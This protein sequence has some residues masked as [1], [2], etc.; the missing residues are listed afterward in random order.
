M[1]RQN[2]ALTPAAGRQ[3]LVR[4]F[5][6]IDQQYVYSHLKKK[7]CLFQQ[8]D[9]AYQDY[10][11][12]RHFIEL[13]IFAVWQS[14]FFVNRKNYSPYLFKADVYS[15]V[16]AFLEVYD[17]SSKA[18]KKFLIQR[19]RKGLR[20]GYD[21]RDLR[22]EFDVYTHVRQ[23]GLGIRPYENKHGKGFDFLVSDSE[24]EAEIEV[25]HISTH[26]GHKIHQGD[27]AK[28]GELFSSQAEKIED[29]EANKICLVT[30]SDRFPSHP[31]E[32]RGLVNDI[33]RLAASDENKVC[34][35]Y[36]IET[37]LADPRNFPEHG[38]FNAE[39]DYQ[40]AIRSACESQIGVENTSMCVLFSRY[41][42][43]CSILFVSSEPD[44]YAAR[45]ESTIKRAAFEQ[46]TRKRPGFIT[47]GL[48]GISNAEMQILR[49]G[50][51]SENNKF[52]GLA[53]FAYRIFC[54]SGLEH[55]A[56]LAFLGDP[57]LT[58]AKMPPQKLFNSGGDRT[59]T[60]N[61]PVYSVHN[62]RA[63]EHLKVFSALFSHK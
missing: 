14:I 24:F 47:I 30:L 40:E 3:M 12:Q 52:V 33:M 19:V 46:L 26:K 57:Y 28:L 17:L 41:G 45:I 27:F 61:R 44:R 1:N 50:R 53:S 58:S 21:L 8:S 18:N 35:Q 29:L 49:E 42:V 15:F 37:F 63:P 16:A 60:S 11:L 13:G 6:L 43:A 55:L 62:P 22:L 48:E 7:D 38:Q 32:Q 56:G 2:F 10:F 5:Q 4:F 34:A 20:L 23:A 36:K 31:A 9:A 51:L 59:I 54:T 25:K 39:R